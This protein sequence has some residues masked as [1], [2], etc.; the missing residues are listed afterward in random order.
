VVAH[1]CA[2]LAAQNAHAS[3]EHARHSVQKTSFF[4]TRNR[5]VLCVRGADARGRRDGGPKS[6]GQFT[7]HRGLHV[8]L[9]ERGQEVKAAAAAAVVV[10]VVVVVEVV[11]V[12]LICSLV[13]IA[14][15]AIVT[16]TLTWKTAKTTRHLSKEHLAGLR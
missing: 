7:S 16:V 3:V 6:A 14:V 4:A 9:S 11:E 15:V 13:V 12:V 5:C 8:V 2:R 1:G 10:V